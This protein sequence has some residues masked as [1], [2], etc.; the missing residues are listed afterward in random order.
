M[1]ASAQIKKA[2]TVLRREHRNHH[3]VSSKK[4]LRL[5]AAALGKRREE[6]RMSRTEL[7]EEVGVSYFTMAHIELGEN[8]PSI[9]VYLAICKALQVGVP[10]LMK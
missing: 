6:M 9:P 4:A 7:A 5:F 8:W 3:T 1:T 10:P 2:A